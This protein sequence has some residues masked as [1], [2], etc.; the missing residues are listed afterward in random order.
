MVEMI[1]N[2]ISSDIKS[3]AEEKLFHEFRNYR[4]VNNYFILHSLGI[5]EH[6]NNIFGEIDFV[7]ICHRGVLCIEIKGGQ[8]GCHHGVWEFTNRYGKKDKK[9][10]S[11]FKQAQGNMHS[12]RN[13]MKKRL[14]KNDPL[15]TCQYASC[16]IMPDCRFDAESPEIIPE[17]LFDK[18]SF[19]CLDQ[20]VEESF[21]YWSGQLRVKHGF[22]GTELTDY[23]MKRLSDLLRG[24]FHFIPTVKETVDDTAKDLCLLTDEQYDI[25]ESLEDNDRTLVSGAAGTGKTLLAM[26]Q[27]RRMFQSGKNVLYVCFNRNIA[28]YVQYIFE[29]EDTEVTAQTLHSIMAENEDIN[30]TPDDFFDKILPAKFLKKSRI[31]KY[32]YLIIDEGQDLF[33]DAYIPCLDRLLHGGLQNGCW[34]IFYD[35]NQNL[36]SQS[37]EFDRNL[38]KLKK[39]EAATFKLTVNCRNTKQIADANSLISGFKDATKSKI[40]GP[41]VQYIPYSDKQKE[42]HLLEDTLRGLKNEGISGND[43]ILLSK[44]SVNNSRN[45]LHSVSMPKDIGILKMDGQIWCA[46][47]NEVRFSTISAFKGLEANVLL[48][49]DVDSFSDENARLLN[50]VAVSRAVTLLYVFYDW[51]REHERQDMMI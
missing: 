28:D 38:Y 29:K 16:V 30:E 40:Q 26:E 18:N 50:Y 48:L 41:K 34:L 17:I 25:L 46:K 2:I 47:K 45:C 36:F 31:R 21:A 6:Q 32:D 11:P 20:I 12:L 10:E 15:V 5:S 27:A 19:I 22:E 33:K 24:D 4:T 14:D 9:T 51:N 1:P 49:L 39:Y 7:V 44:Y 43:L 37:N 35:R 42:L 8:V 13:Y 3:M 23:Q